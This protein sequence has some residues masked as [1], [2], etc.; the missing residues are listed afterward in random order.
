MRGRG[1]RGGATRRMSCDVSWMS[2]KS[3]RGKSGHLSMPA[4]DLV[5]D[6]DDEAQLGALRLDR[7]VVAVHRAREAALGR[8][9]QLLDRHVLRRLVDAALQV[10]LRFELAE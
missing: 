6:L 10:V 8:Q 3:D 4:P 7:D 1:C 9:A 5:G 2:R